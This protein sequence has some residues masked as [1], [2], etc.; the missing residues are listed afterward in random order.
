[1]RLSCGIWGIG[2]EEY[3]AER[4]GLAL[5]GDDYGKQQRF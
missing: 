4:P 2:K 1:M 5:S 3:L